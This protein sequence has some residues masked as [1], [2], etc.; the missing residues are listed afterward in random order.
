MPGKC[1]TCGQ[2]FK[3]FGTTCKTC[4]SGGKPSFKCPHCN[5]T[6]TSNTPVC[7]SCGRAAD[8]V[9]GPKVAAIHDDLAQRNC[10][11]CGKRFAPNDPGQLYKDQ[12]YHAACLSCDRCSKPLGEG[13]TIKG[14]EKLCNACA[15]SEVCAGCGKKIV[16]TVTT[17]GGQK[18][19]PECFQCIECKAPIKGPHVKRDGKPV[20]MDCSNKA[21]G[22]ASAK[23]GGAAPSGD[24]C[25]R[26][27]KQTTGAV[28]RTPQ[29][30]KFH[31]DC[32]TCM[33]K[34]CTTSLQAGFN[35]K[36]DLYV[37]PEHTM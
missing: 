16:G 22:G 15:T 25:K 20:C 34:G 2:N 12:R 33:H 21:K 36:G 17:V 32:F 11:G 10:N 18:Y 29:G 26:C 31:K 14:Q 3:G 28:F 35:L 5:I 6:F 4:R 23:A 19:H 30:D 37:C 7:D 8:Q 1:D 13:L 27:G 9:G 24:V